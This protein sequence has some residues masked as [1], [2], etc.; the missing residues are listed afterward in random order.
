[1]KYHGWKLRKKPYELRVEHDNLANIVF[2][3]YIESLSLRYY[4]FYLTSLA[5]KKP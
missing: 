5:L 4:K 3:Q 2:Y 1:M